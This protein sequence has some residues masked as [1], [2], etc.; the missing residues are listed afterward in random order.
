MGK[1]KFN[2]RPNKSYNLSDGVVWESRSVAIT[3]LIMVREEMT[4]NLYVLISK[5]GKGTPDFQGYWNLVCGYLDWDENATQACFREVWEE[6]NIDLGGIIRSGTTLLVEKL[7]QPYFVQSEPTSN[8]QNVTLRHGVCLSVENMEKFKTNNPCSN[9]NS[10]PNEVDDYVWINIDDVDQYKFAFN[11]N[12][13][14]IDF[15]SFLD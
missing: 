2:N 6:T 5:R 10:E 3:C 7:S 13:I 9:I 12:D 14:I 1:I 4:G 11:H 8:R 15:L